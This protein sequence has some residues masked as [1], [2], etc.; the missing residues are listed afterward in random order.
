MTLESFTSIAYQW[1]FSSSC[2]PVWGS[3]VHKIEDDILVKEYFESLSKRQKRVRR[4]VKKQPSPLVATRGI[5]YGRRNEW[6]R[7]VPSGR[8]AKLAWEPPRGSWEHKPFHID[9]YK[10]DSAETLMIYITWL[11]GHKTRHKVDMLC[12]KCP[13]KVTIS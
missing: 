1:I 13:Q 9:G 6:H 5:G 11:G 10:G 3:Y 8:T 2:G 12:K 4:S 7:T